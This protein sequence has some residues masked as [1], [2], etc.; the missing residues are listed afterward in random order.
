MLHRDSSH[1]W[2]LC[3]INP[4]GL[5]TCSKGWLSL[6]AGGDPQPHTGQ[7]TSVV[8]PGLAQLLACVP[9]CHHEPHCRPRWFGE[10]RQPTHLGCKQS[11]LEVC[12]EPP[13]PPLWGT[14][15]ATK[16]DNTWMQAPKKKRAR[17][18]ICCLYLCTLVHTLLLVPYHKHI[19]FTHLLPRFT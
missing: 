18:G 5:D 9:G 19:C 10:K 8:T 11:S 7:R 3:S 17:A 1:A 6:G 13:S 15:K 16:E 4:R 2:E 12:I 14:Q